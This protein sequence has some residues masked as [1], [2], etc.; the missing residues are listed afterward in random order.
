MLA[1]AQRHLFALQLGVGPKVV[2]QVFAEALTAVHGEVMTEYYVHSEGIDLDRD[3]R[4]AVEVVVLCRILQEPALCRQLVDDP[5]GRPQELRRRRLLVAVVLGLQAVL[6]SLRLIPGG[7]Y[8]P[9]RPLVLQLGCPLGRLV[10]VVWIGELHAPAADHDPI[11]RDHDHAGLVS[12]LALRVVVDTEDE[13]WLATLDAHLRSSLDMYAPDGTPP[14]P[15]RPRLTFT[16]GTGTLSSV[17]RST[18][19]PVPQAAWHF[20]TPKRKLTVNPGWRSP[21]AWFAEKTQG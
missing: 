13:R 4:D 7:L 3:L 14:V 10:K 18:R 9:I 5:P 12:A 8:R 15:I 21:W 2:D 17:A 1:M 16:P 11:A 19:E 6:A 20:H